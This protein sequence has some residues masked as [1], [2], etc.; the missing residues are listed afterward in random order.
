MSQSSYSELL[1]HPSWQKKRLEILQLHNFQCQNCGDTESPLHVHHGH[2]EKGKMPWEYKNDSL[3]CLCE[4]CHSEIQELQAVMRKLIGKLY[5]DLD[6]NQAGGYLLAILLGRSENGRALVLNPE[7]AMG[8]GDY[9]D[10]SPEEILAAL[11]DG[12]W[13]RVVRLRQLRQK[14]YE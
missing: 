7:M 14:H 6:I 11:D 1:K 3:H 5:S 13:I 4:R 12:G 8:I 10:L 2:Y 9:F